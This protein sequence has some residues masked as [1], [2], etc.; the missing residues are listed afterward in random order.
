MKIKES[1]LSHP[2]VRL[3][4]SVL[5]AFFLHSP[6]SVPNTKLIWSFVSSEECDECT[7]GHYFITQLSVTTSNIF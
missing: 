5:L 2:S 3:P 7:Y 1:T 4:I 6:S